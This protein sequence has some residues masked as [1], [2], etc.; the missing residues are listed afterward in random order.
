MPYETVIL[1]YL[2][3]T[4]LDMVNILCGTSD[5]CYGQNW[6]IVL[7]LNLPSLMSFKKAVRK[8]D[9]ESLLENNSDCIS[10]I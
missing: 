6:V 1:I 8:I 9:I 2:D 7:S 3:L 4:L 10:S 5:L